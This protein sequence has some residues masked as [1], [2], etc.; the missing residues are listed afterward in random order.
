M[1][2]ELD[3]LPRKVAAIMRDFKPGWFI[4]GG[5]AIDLYLG[6]VTRP[7]ADIEVGIFRA[8][9]SAL[10]DY[11]GGWRL[12]KVAGGVRSAWR[13][14]ELL[15]PPVHELYCFNAAAELPR[16][17]ILLN[18]SDGGR[19]VYRRD[20]RI[21]RPLGKCLLTSGAGVNY[22]CPEVVLLYKSKNPREKDEQDF[23]AAAARLDAES[24][25]WL[26]SAIAACDAG[27]HW[28]RSL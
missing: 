23:G 13:R 9:Q 18:E 3:R 27:H 15:A 4:A 7:H 28:L 21:T 8:D 2:S 16:L 17:E 11:F 19:W 5:W 26:R 20:E 25:V 12:Q 22:L 24:R 10:Q 1:S 14:G 6:R